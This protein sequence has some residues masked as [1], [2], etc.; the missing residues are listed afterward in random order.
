MAKNNTPEIPRIPLGSCG[1]MGVGA[2][3]DEGKAVVKDDFTYFPW[4]IDSDEIVGHI[5]ESQ[6][7]YL[8]GLTKHGGK[9]F[10]VDEATKVIENFDIVFIICLASTALDNTLFI[11]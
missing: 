9:V 1:G 11:V 8:Q 6:S 4:D 10:T 5:E 3:T 2:A 7:D